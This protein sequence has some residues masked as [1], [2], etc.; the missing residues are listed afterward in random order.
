[1]STLLDLLPAGIGPAE[2]AIMGAVFVSVLVVT[3]GVAA[4][5][6]PQDPVSRRF[7]EAGTLSAGSGPVSIDLRIDREPSKAKG[8]W[9]FL[10]PND[11]KERSE[12]RRRLW[13]AGFTSP[14]VVRNYYLVRALLA[15]LLPLPI[16][17]VVLFTSLNIGGVLQLD[18]GSVSFTLPLLLV[19]LL[20]A[21]GFYGP[22]AIVRL[23]IDARQEAVRR[24]FPT[25]L[26]LLQLSVESGLGVDAAIQKVA[27]EMAL[28]QPALAREFGTIL[29]EL[30]AGKPR[31]AVLADFAER[32]GVEEVRSFVAVL[33]QTVEFGTD[34]VEALR[35]FASEMRRRRMLLAEEKA[36]KLSVKLSIVIVTIMLPTIL[37]L[38]M[39]PIVIRA[40]RIIVPAL[41][42]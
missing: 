26:D 18:L 40:I 23:R 2:L 27:E 1:M 10:L 36:N 12:V 19:L 8:I 17:A 11:D 37:M 3:W 38:I 9:G 42:G 41:A 7:T 4:L 32:T 33:Q 6:A 15:L 20:V 16:V 25:A 22:A 28:A 35:V 30:R 34:I 5:T 31:Q 24:A 14:H 29:V 39:G 21:L 13:R